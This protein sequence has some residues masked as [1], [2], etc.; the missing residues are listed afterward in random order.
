MIIFIVDSNI[1]YSA[2]LNTNSTI[3]DL[4]INSKQEFEFYTPSYLKEEIENHKEKI[5]DY[6][7]ISEEYFQDLRSIIFSNIIFLTDSLIPFRVWREAS[8][9]VRDVDPDDIAYV[10]SSLHFE[11]SIWTGDK[12]L[13]N[14]LIAKGYSKVISTQELFELRSS[15]RNIQHG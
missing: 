12:E 7:K 1:I 4:L 5:K 11:K 10:A 2:F 13:Y 8:R 3:G 9:L 15:I 6:T 14:G